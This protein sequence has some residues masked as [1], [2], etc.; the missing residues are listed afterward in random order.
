MSRFLGY[1][2]PF[3]KYIANVHNK[4]IISEDEDELS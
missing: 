2:P 3:R 4:L 1:I